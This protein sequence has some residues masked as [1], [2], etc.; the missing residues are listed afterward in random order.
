[1]SLYG[2]V[3]SVSEG[4]GTHYV[5]LMF[6]KGS[7]GAWFNPVVIV[8]QENMGVKV[9]DMMGVVATVSGVFEEQDAS[10]NDLAVPRLEL[11]FVDKVE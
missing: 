5:R 2:P 4:G 9:G 6:N 3:T 7:D 10:G 11:V 1:M 8:A